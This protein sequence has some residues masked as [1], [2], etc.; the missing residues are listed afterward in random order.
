MGKSIT[1]WQGI[2][3]MVGFVA[4]ACGGD[5]NGSSNAAA[6]SAGSASGAGANAQSG[7][8]GAGRVGGASSISSGGGAG[9]SGGSAVTGGTTAAGGMTPSGGSTAAG[10]TA[11]AGGAAAA[12]GSAPSGGTTVTGGTAAGASAT[13]GIA[14]T[15]GTTNAGG[16]E[17]TAGARDSGGTA[18]SAGSSGEGAFSGGPSTG[19]TGTAGSATGGMSAGGAQTGGAA[20]GGGSGGDPTCSM[21]VY[22]P[23]DP[24]E[25]F[26]PGGGAH[27]PTAIKVGDTFYRFQ[28]GGRI[29]ALTSGSIGS[30]WRN[31][32]NALPNMASWLAAELGGNPADFWAPDVIYIG[33]KYHLYYSASGFGGNRSCIGHA[34]QDQIS[35]TG[36]QDTGQPVICTYGVENYNAID[37][38]VIIDQDGTPWMSFGSFWDGIM[39][40]ELDS[41][42]NRVGN[43]VENLASGPDR[44]GEGPFMIYRCGYYYLFLS[45]G[46]CCPGASGRTANDLTY[47][48]VV[49]RAE[50]V[51]GPFA[52]REGHALLNGG[53]TVVV[54]GYGAPP[55]YAAG[56]GEWLLADGVPYI[57]Y[58]AYP[59]G[60]AN[61]FRASELVWDEEGW[62][63]QVGP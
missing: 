28:T 29:G 11:P 52:D 50:S 24:P 34:T 47:N 38:D 44:D 27:D 26:D 54:E 51:H 10:G 49:G 42:G 35:A 17:A 37:P 31:E 13:G 7:G 18:P 53:G 1:S 8:M 59:G 32:G 20:T 58:H 23:E 39:L 15:G 6:G 56:H 2:G 36:W 14:S 3:C 5:G 4:I 22:D 46:I 9:P 40:I 43:S 30:G 55:F 48:I 60:T 19:G 57:I 41:D 21:G 63:V 33:G 12:G 61:E 62:P 45:H 25:L 16:S